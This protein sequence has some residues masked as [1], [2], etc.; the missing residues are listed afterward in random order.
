MRTIKIKVYSFD[1]LTKEAKENAIENI[2]QEYYQ[3]NLGSIDFGRLA[4]DDCSLFEPPHK[5]L[6]DL[7]GVAYDFPLIKNTR[8]NI[9]FST[10]RN[11]FLDCAEAM[12]IT[13]DEQFLKWLGLPDEVINDEDFSYEIL[14]SNYRNS[15]TT[16]NFDGYRSDFDDYIEDAVK[17]FN[18]H[19]HDVLKRIESDID[20]RYTDEAIIE[21]IQGNEYEFLENGEIY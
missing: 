20:Y 11:W 6:E 21:D 7:F 2:R 13:N 8:K 4:V 14:T 9:Y 18:N 3:G 16:I 19:I 17:K 1:E 10:D 5:E 15:D 12:E